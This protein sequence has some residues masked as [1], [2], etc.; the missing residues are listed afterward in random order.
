MRSMSVTKATCQ[1]RSVGKPN[2]LSLVITA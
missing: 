2:E 1:S